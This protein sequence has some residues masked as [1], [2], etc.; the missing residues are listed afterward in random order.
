[1]GQNRE[2][3]KGG[4]MP[5]HLPEDL[6]YFKKVTLGKKVLMGRKTYESIGKPLPGRINIVLTRD[7]S[8][9]PPGVIV[10]HSKKEALD[11]L[12]DHDFIIGGAEIYN[13]FLPYITRVYVT[14]IFESF[15]ADAYFPKFEGNW[16][17]L[18]SDKGKGNSALEY[19]FI[20]LEKR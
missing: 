12:C 17:L 9:N 18:S 3:G 10:V 7:K 2:I 16:E 19:Y 8:F 14:K 15:E 4:R 13:Q 5:W 11:L 6:T 1:M 20:V